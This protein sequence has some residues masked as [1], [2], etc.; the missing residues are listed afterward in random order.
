MTHQ[1]LA[2]STPCGP[3]N[4]SEHDPGHQHR[5]RH[6]PGRPD[7]HAD[8]LRG[9]TRD[10]LEGEGA[11]DEYEGS[12]YFD[13]EEP[14]RSHLEL[15]ISASSINTGN[16][17]RDNHL[18]SNDFF[19]MENHPSIEF[20]STA[21]ERTGEGEYTVTGDLTMKGVTRP[22]SVEFQVEGPVKDPFGM[23]R[24]GLEGSAK[25]NRKDWGIEWNAPWRPA[26]CSWAEKVTLEFD[27]SA[28]AASEDG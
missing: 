25:V 27:V 24:I 17:D 16:E 23:I 11:F 26:V 10:G 2:G 20:R 15:T 14:S 22:V 7:P 8:R 5:H 18:R 21:V 3:T 6:L 4:R 12:G 1:R 19:D 28:V 13:A 9:P